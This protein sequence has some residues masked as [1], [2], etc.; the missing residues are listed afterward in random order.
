MVTAYTPILKL[1][2]PVQG[3]LSGTWG[4]VVNDNITSM[5]EQAIAGR[6]VI[7]TWTTNS[8][9]LT[10]ANG[11]TSE[12]RCAMLEFTDTG[13]ALSGAGTVICPT[14]SKIYIAKNASGQNVT[15]KTSGG[16]GILVPNGRTMFLFC[17]GTNVV[18]AVTST[19]SLQL[20]TSTIVTAVLDEDDMASDSATSLATQQSIKAY[21]DSQVGA[22]NELSEVLAN[23]NTSGANDIIMTSGQKITVDTIDETT[24]AAGVTI[25][26]VLLKDDGVNATNLEITNIK[27]NDG[28]AAGS[29]ADSTGVV[30]VLSSI[31]TTA[32]IN[33]GTAD[34][35]IIGGTTPA[36]A[37]VTNLIANTDLIIAGTTTINAILD[38]DNMASDSAAALATQQS[39]KAY[40]DA[41]VGTVDTLAEI[42]AIGNTTGGTDLA[43]STGD[44]IT[45]ADSSKAIFGAGSDLQIYHDSNN[46]YIADT[47]TGGLRLLADADTAIRSAD[48]STPKAI[49][50]GDV[51][52]YYSG[53]L[54]IATTATGIDVTGTVTADGLGVEGLISTTASQST[55]GQIRI[56]NST[57]RASGNKYGIRFADSSFETNASIYAEQLS[58]GANGADLIFGTNNSTGGIGLTSATERMRIGSSGGLITNPTTGGHAVFNEAGV[59][60]DFRV[61]SDTNTHALFV[62][63]S[64]GYVGIGTSSVS[65]PLHIKST[66]AI[67][68]LE[69]TA[70]GGTTYNI[71][72]GI[73]GVSE[74]GLSFRDITNSATRLA[75][76]SSGNVLVGKTAQ[77]V[78]TVGGEILSTGIGQF[79][80]NGNFAGRFTRQTSDG[81]IVV[82][83]KGTGTVASIGISQSGSVP[84]IGGTDTGICFNSAT[85]GV[86]P[87]D[88]SNPTA[89][90]ID[91]AKDLGFST[92]R[93]RDLYLSGG[94]QGAAAGSIVINEAGLDVDFRV[95][96][97]ADTHA[98]FLQ[99]SDGFIG[100]GT[101]SPLTKIHI[102]STSVGNY[103]AFLMSQLGNTS[104]NTTG[105]AFKFNSGGVS[106]GN[107][108]SSKDAAA[109]SNLTFSTGSPANGADVQR[110]GISSLGGII[111]TSVAGG[112]VVFNENGVDADFRVESDTNANALIVDGATG[113]I[114][115]SLASTP[116]GSATTEG[117][118]YTAG[119]GFDIA[120]NTNTLRVNRNS[121][122]GNDRVNI[123]LQNNGTTRAEFGSLGAENG[124]YL[125]DSTKAIISGYSDEV[126]INET[127]ADINFRVESDTNANML[128]VDA[129]NNSVGIG[130]GSPVASG[131]PT[132]TI[133]TRTIVGKVVEDQSMFS[134]NAFYTGA[135]WTTKETDSWAAIRTINNSIRFHTG[136]THTA[137]TELTAMDASSMRLYISDTEAV[138]NDVSADADFRV[139]SDGNANMLFVDAG[140]NEVGIGTGSPGAPLHVQTTHTS[141]DVTAANSN[142]TVI[143]ANSGVG[144]GIYNAIKFAG[145]QQ[146]MYIMSFNNSAT[147][148]RRLGF[149]LGSVAGDAVADERLSIT[150]DGNVGIGTSSPNAS[151]HVIGDAIASTFKL[152]A[153]TTV[154]GSDATIFR[155]ADNTM[156]L[157]TGGVE[158]MRIDGSGNV[159]INGTTTVGYKFH[160]YGDSAFERTGTTS[161]TMIVFRNGN[162]NVGTINTSGSSTSYNTSSDYRLKTDAQPMTGASD[163][164]LAL[165]PVNF[166]WLLTALVSMVSLHMKHRLSF[167]SVSLAPKTQCVTKNM[168][169]QQQLKPHTMKMATS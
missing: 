60:A 156:A 43:V 22:N 151:L 34:G 168:K 121:T 157:S 2:L 72:N 10:T 46:S 6:A 24:A 159:L 147:A 162:G 61:E 137:G 92:I 107:I 101:A 45:F 32:D 53:N 134:D 150:G 89:V 42:L 117:L 115:F 48:N 123:E 81:D 69:P 30:T 114:G 104:G 3:E 103:T 136:G 119:A 132:V 153:N 138:F 71:R 7:D 169:S 9:T 126:V 135:I 1:A 68:R 70:V 19:T 88:T 62:E 110:L 67:I 11:T 122:G 145:N 144:N 28:T 111:A 102:N 165:K 51:K 44:D 8:H 20:G 74:G 17:D 87:A 37:T 52:L 73:S 13:T 163:R 80:V 91:A 29:I 16:T 167:L 14:L 125:S 76:D 161:Q 35:V 78:D 131:L 49:F 149:F 108:S 143:V 128:L 66:R 54:K 98:L 77:S 127:G 141:T 21:V 129:G 50:G 86:L 27:A 148:D 56:R 133:G 59:D 100:V 140:S 93:W 97:D 142:S 120:S 26:S 152:I 95:E 57:T 105:L 116:Y 139:E 124:F 33:G 109:G 58:S 146:D 15:L 75:I 47:G 112:H 23:G 36:A 5:V 158:R 64:S 41:Q 4:D 96:S 39:I 160:V 94:I 130:T 38:E 90:Q 65:E 118:F 106:G 83:R 99:G 164:V 40:V 31:L 18:E 82:F 154:S 166:E 84:Y 155:P 12:S 113:N 55:D 85:N 63:G 79:T 25:D